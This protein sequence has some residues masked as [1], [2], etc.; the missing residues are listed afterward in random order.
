MSSWSVL[1]SLENT[2]MSRGGQA[3]PTTSTI[4]SPTSNH[5]K[6]HFSLLYVHETEV[7]PTPSGILL[8]LLLAN[9]TRRQHATH[10]CYTPRPDPWSSAVPVWRRYCIG[11][12]TMPRPAGA[13]PGGVHQERPRCAGSAMAD[14]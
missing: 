1:A 7:D 5:V 10:P 14:Q 2:S 12:R 3:P 6:Y 9:S 8:A 4:S 13:G 11:A